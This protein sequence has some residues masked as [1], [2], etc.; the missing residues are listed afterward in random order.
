M[1]IMKLPRIVGIVSGLT[2]ALAGSSVLAQ[3]IARVSVSSSL[4]QGNDSSSQGVISGDGRYIAFFSN[5]TNLVPGDTNAHSDVFVHDYQTGATTRASVSSGGLQANGSSDSPSISSDGRYVAFE[6]NATNLVTGDTNGVYDVF[7]HDRTTNM[8]V[9]VSVASSGTEGNNTSV[10]PTVS[11]DGRFVAFVSS[12]NNLVLNDTNGSD[13]VFV[14]DLQNGTT[15]LISVDSASVQ[16][17]GSSSSPKISADGRY[18]AFS[19]NATNLVPGDTNA[20]SDIFIHDMQSGV[21]LSPTVDPNWVIGNA[22]SDSPWLSPDGRFVA[23]RSDANNFVLGDTNGQSDVFVQD[24]QTS[25]ILRAS[26]DSSGVEGNG[27]SFNPSISADGRFLAFSSYSSNLV[28]GDTNNQQD[29]FVHNFQTGIT[30]RVSS[31]AVQSDSVSFNPSISSD[32]RY[33][34]SDSYADNV[35]PG[36]TNQTYDVFLYD[37]LGP[38]AGFPIYC[39]AKANSQGCLPEICASGTPSISGPDNFH[40]TA[41]YE[42][43][44]KTGIFLWSLGQNSVPLGGG[45]LCLHSP[46]TRTPGQNSGG[47]P[48]VNDCT[49]TYSFF[50]SQAYMAAHGLGSGSTVYGQYWSR[51]PFFPPPTNV[52]LSNG[53][54]F[55]IGP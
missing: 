53:I 37:P 23:F 50:F 15:V 29:T 19:S 46:I 41:N 32:G 34:T 13:D 7:L 8:T 51:D 5:A 14:R 16:G 2:C 21:T 9:R 20:A 1:K 38:C 44:N 39:E 43:N 18:V 55:T 45:T 33:V 3:T 48:G 17:N 54:Q 31:L 28:P 26:V 22:G 52:G 25:I 47:T 40:V 49:G 27:P 42:L 6:S 12:A 10:S 30:T 36:D 4:S 35:V 24:T 11:A